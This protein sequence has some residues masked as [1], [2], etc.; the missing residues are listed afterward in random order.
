MHSFERLH[1]HVDRAGEERALGADHQFA[2]VERLFDRAVGRGL[3]DLAQLR[4]G[5]EYWPFVRP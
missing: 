5:G 1:L 2:G 4:G 3:G